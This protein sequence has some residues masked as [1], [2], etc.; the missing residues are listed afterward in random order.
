MMRPGIVRHG[1]ERGEHFRQKFLIFALQRSSPMHGFGQFAAILIERQAPQD[2][3][4][5]QR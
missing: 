1:V 5:L 3:I 4:R 2:S